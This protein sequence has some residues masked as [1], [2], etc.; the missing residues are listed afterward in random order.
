MRILLKK[1][2]KK[3]TICVYCN[4]RQGKKESVSFLLRERNLRI[5]L[6]VYNSSRLLFF[7]FRILFL[8]APFLTTTYA[9]ICVCLRSCN[10]RWQCEF[11]RPRIVLLRKIH[12]HPHVNPFNEFNLIDDGNIRYDKISI[13]S[14]HRRDIFISY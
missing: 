13:P 11:G 9:A 5:W 2:T 4:Q 10:A 3:N 12:L 7:Y 6:P 14:H 1:K 8:F